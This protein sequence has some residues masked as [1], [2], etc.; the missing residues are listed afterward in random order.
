MGEGYIAATIEI[1][2]MDLT[3]AVIAFFLFFQRHISHFS[4]IRR[5]SWCLEEEI[6][7][8]RGELG[9]LAAI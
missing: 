2:H 9:N 1:L 8:R 6:V 4:A 3:G 5:P 7:A